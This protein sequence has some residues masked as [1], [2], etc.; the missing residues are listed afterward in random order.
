MS[1]NRSACVSCQH[2]FLVFI[3]TVND[4]Q[5]ELHKQSYIN[6]WI[7][8]NSIHVPWLPTA[9]E[10]LVKEGR[11]LQN[12][13]HS[14]FRITG[15]FHAGLLEEQVGSKLCKEGGP[16]GAGLDN[17]QFNHRVRVVSLDD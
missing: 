4:T 1:N 5:K 15:N 8:I 11:S 14:L 2:I 9:S 10:G 13:K 7:N 16:S 6:I 12:R 17:Q 3:G